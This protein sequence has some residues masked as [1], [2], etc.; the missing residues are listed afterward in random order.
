MFLH[1]VLGIFDTTACN[2]L[3]NKKRHCLM[4]AESITLENVRWASSL[5]QLQRERGLVLFLKVDF[6]VKRPQSSCIIY[7]CLLWIAVCQSS[8]LPLTFTTIEKLL[9]ISIL[10]YLSGKILL[11]DETIWGWTPVITLEQ[12]IDTQFFSHFLSVS[13]LS[14]F[15]MPIHNSGQ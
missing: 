15:F 10:F 1:E 3:K 6:W 5:Q 2:H 13:L 7:C 4:I 12:G 11:N 8:I 9:H 14:F